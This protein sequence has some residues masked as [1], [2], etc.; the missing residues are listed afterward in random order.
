VTAEIV[1]PCDDLHATLAFF[2]ELG[3]RVDAISP[4]T[5][6]RPR[7]SRATACGSGSHAAARAI[8]A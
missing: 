7:S 2:E 8:P 4:P 6:R 3:F 1:L 5:I